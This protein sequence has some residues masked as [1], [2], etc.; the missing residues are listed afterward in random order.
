[1]SGFVTPPAG[2]VN[3]RLG[4]VA[5]E[6]DLGYTGDAFR[7]NGTTLTDAVNPATNFFNSS[8]SRFGATVTTKNPNY[9]NQLGFDIDLVSANGILRQ[10]RD[11]RHHL[12][13]LDRRYLLPGVVT[14]ATDLYAPVLSGNGFNKTVTDLNGGRRGPATCSSTRCACATPGNDDATTVVMRDT[15]PAN[16]HLRAGLALDRQRTERRRQD[17]RHRRRPGRVR[18]RAAH[19]RR[20]TRHRRQRR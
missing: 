17:R 14:F 12:A 18:R 8:I 13:H 1:M 4:V 3:T 20:A 7:L 2:A 9:L 5:Y 16:A 10:R 15:L 6:G 19:D 11:Q